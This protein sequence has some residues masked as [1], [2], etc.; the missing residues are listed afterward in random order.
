MIKYR[1]DL[2]TEM[3]RGAIL[4]TPNNRLSN[5][6]LR[7][8][9]K[10]STSTV[11]NKPRCLPY[12]TFLRELFQ[13]VQH[14]HLHS[15]HPVLLSAHQERFLWQE[16]IADN[17]HYSCTNNLLQEIQNA[18]THCQHWSIDLTSEL[19][20]Q[21]HQTQQFQ[22][23]CTIFHNFLTT[24]NAITE[25][26]LVN[27]I[28]NHRL[29][30]LKKPMHWIS[31]DDYTPQQLELQAILEN[32][33]CSQHYYD[34]EERSQTPLLYEARDTQD[35]IEKLIEWLNQQLDAKVPR[36]AVIVPDLMQQSQSLQR[37]LLRSI[38]ASQFDIS[39]GKKLTEFPLVAHALHWL[40]LDTNTFNNHQIKLLLHSPYITGSRSE[41]SQRSALLEE[42]KILLE[43]TTPFNNLVS[44]LQATP[45]LSNILNQLS[46]YPTTA[47]PHEWISQFKN[48]LMILGFPGDYTL[49]SSTYQC[50]QRFQ[51]LFDD[52]LQLTF[53]KHQM[54]L[55]EALLAFH[56]IAES[57]VFQVRK[58]PS[59]IQILGLLEASGCE[60]DSVWVTGL[61]DQT[62]P[63]KVKLS[64]FI[65]ISIQREHHMPHALNEKEVLLAKQLLNRIKNGSQQCIFSYPRLTADTPNLPSPLVRNLPSFQA[66]ISLAKK[67][68]LPLIS[69][70]EP[71]NC[72]ITENEPISGGT[73]LLANQAK[74]PFRA[75]AAHRLHAKPTLKQT[76]GIDDAGRGQLIHKI[77]ELIW[78]ELGNQQTLLKQS[79]HSLNTLIHQAIDTALTPHIQQRTHSFQPLVQDIERKRLIQLAQACLEWDKQRPPFEIKALEE[80]YTLTLAGLDFKVRVDRLDTI[81]EHETWVIDYKSTL[82]PSKPWNEE[83]PEAPQLLL[84]ALL[85]PSINALLFLQLKTGQ[86]ACSGI[87]Q[88]DY[89]LTGLSTIKK[90]ES[91]TQLRATWHE[92]LTHLATEFQK[93][94]CSPKPQRQS[95][96][97]NCE[98]NNLCRITVK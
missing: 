27:Y 40:S 71:Y 75:F 63:Q 43:T 90:D 1:S 74:C 95:T 53:V 6:L 31:F 30:V 88:D 51:T 49:N 10:T 81:T 72:P 29:D 42:S 14:T 28:S 33:G 25:A 9:M 97:L 85:D 69:D 8:F 17:E 76:M 62:L 98:Y 79:N 84:Y 36:I 52:F 20:S 60:F 65:P 67:H 3:A 35:E 57:T 91:W 83:R 66:K 16:I 19:F 50:L 44:A 47:P 26:Q 55:S 64:P 37:R 61:T 5:Q 11:C 82:P 80:A 56:E 34:F 24:H 12:N 87:S 92:R 77:M 32:C 22:A 21:S 46:A 45:K 41:F 2:Y 4:I 86:M 39:L 54:T 96:C 89:E 38:P 59:S 68:Q 58:T 48:R 78:K 18:W 73:A 70:Q 15:T 7:E 94:L 23:W 93:G 13:Q